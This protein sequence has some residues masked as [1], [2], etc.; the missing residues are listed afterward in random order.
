MGKLEHI[1]W[2]CFISILFSTMLCNIKVQSILFEEKIR[3]EF[4][5]LAKISGQ[6]SGE[7]TK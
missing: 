7:G 4:M 2:K 1:T 3:K 6:Y 5:T